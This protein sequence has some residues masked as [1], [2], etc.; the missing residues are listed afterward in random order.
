MLMF[1]VKVPSAESI[2]QRVV[3]AWNK[4]GANLE[5]VRGCGKPDLA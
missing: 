3:F 4:G 5:I 2:G 1:C